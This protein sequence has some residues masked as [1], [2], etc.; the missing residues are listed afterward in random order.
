MRLVLDEINRR[1]RARGDKEVVH[2]SNIMS[3]Y[4]EAHSEHMLSVDRLSKSPE[5]FRDGWI[6]AVAASPASWGGWEDMEK[7]LVDLLLRDDDGYEIV[8]KVETVA[9]GLAFGD[10]RGYLTVRGQ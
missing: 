10:M 9:Y 3:V 7:G 1:R 2:C 8:Y 6:E 4:C 5:Y